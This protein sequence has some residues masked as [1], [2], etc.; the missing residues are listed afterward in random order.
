MEIF[1][2]YFSNLWS[3]LLNKAQNMGPMS[4]DISWGMHY[5]YYM[6]WKYIHE[7][8]ILWK[9]PNIFVNKKN[10]SWFQHILKKAAIN[11]FIFWALMLKA[12]G[13]EIWKLIKIGQKYDCNP[14][15]FFWVP[16]ITL[17][18]LGPILS[19]YIFSK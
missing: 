14:V 11:G 18:K 10:N 15:I 13:E 17:R 3:R 16:Y 4:T 7:S 1:F 6:G 12:I 19:P 8:K 2:D 5:C 9:K